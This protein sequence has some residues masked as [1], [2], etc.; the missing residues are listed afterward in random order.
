MART[1]AVEK[2]ML[3]K[4]TQDITHDSVK[5]VSEASAARGRQES[6]LK[7]ERHIENLVFF[8]F[9]RNWEGYRLEN[10]ECGTRQTM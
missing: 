5:D 4:S 6:S 2:L 3:L 7:T 10:V 8:H 1:H 9:L